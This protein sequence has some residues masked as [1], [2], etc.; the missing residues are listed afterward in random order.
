MLPA[1]LLVLVLPCGCCGGIFWWLISTLK[2]SEP[3][4]MA[5]ERVRTNPQVIGQLGKPIEESSWMPTGNFSY[6]IINGMASGEATFNFNVAGPKGT[7]HVHAQ[8]LCRGGQWRFL[9]LQVTPAST[10]KLISLPVDN[11]A[12]KAEEEN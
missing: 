5:L 8:A 6:H 3:Y 9:Q 2:S 11:E 12:E 4:Q 7:A 1:A 10:G